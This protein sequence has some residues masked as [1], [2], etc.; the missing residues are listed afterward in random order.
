MAHPY[1]T[2]ARLKRFAAG[3]GE[4][5]ND[6]LDRNRDG[7]ADTDGTYS[8]LSDVL[9]RAASRIDAKLGQ[10]YSVPFATETAATTN[11]YAVAPQQVSDLCDLLAL[12]YLYRWNDPESKD[13]ARLEAEFDADIAEYRSGAAEIPGAAKVDA[14]D[15]ARSWAFEGRGTRVAGG[16]T[17]GDT[18]SPYTSDTV[19]Q[20]DGM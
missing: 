1:T 8:V 14:A 17:D 7:I 18:D 20:A 2:E 4:R 16:V 5:L 10:V 3:K 19:D 9:E 13:A 12:A 11:G 6:L 15:A